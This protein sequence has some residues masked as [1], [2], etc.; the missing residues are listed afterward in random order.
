MPEPER[1]ARCLVQIELEGGPKTRGFLEAVVAHRAGI[2]PKCLTDVLSRLRAQHLI[3]R[4]A[5]SYPGSSG[6]PHDVYSL[7]E[8]TPFERAGLEKSLSRKDALLD[9]NKMKKVGEHYVYLVIYH[10]RLFRQGKYLMTG[11][12]LDDQ[13]ANAADNKCR[14]KEDHF[15]IGEIIVEVKNSREIYHLRRKL[16][17]KLV[18]AAIAHNAQPVL[19][20]GHLSQEARGMCAEFGIAVLELGRQILPIAWKT[21]VEELTNVIGPQ[22]YEFVIQR[23]YQGALSPQ[24]QRDLQIVSNPTWLVEPARVWASKKHIVA[25]NLGKSWR[26]LRKLLYAHTADLA[27]IAA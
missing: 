15:S 20:V 18:R 5:L 23:L 10:S 12:Y 11:R 19:V 25:A 16:F 26:E 7:V 21:A 1:R 8:L 4:T 22:P 13:G 6:K 9:A 24:A 2:A 17:G 27:Q 14:Y 3:C